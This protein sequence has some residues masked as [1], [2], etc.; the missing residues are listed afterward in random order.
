MEG[1]KNE[2]GYVDQSQHLIIQAALKV[3]R[4][5]CLS[6]WGHCLFRSV[7]EMTVSEMYSVPHVSSKHKAYATVSKPIS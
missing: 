4:I 3:V 2:N 1:G 6:L 5:C 7:S